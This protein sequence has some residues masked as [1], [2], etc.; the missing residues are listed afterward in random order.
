M[1]A[2]I[3]RT[4]RKAVA[5]IPVTQTRP[6]PKR[7]S[8]RTTAPP[9]FAATPGELALV[10][11]AAAIVNPW[12]AGH[13]GIPYGSP[14]PTYKQIVYDTFLV[15]SGTQSGN[16]WDSNSG[17]LAIGE[18]GIYVNVKLQYSGLTIKHGSGTD[19]LPV[20]QI[21]R[22]VSITGG[23]MVAAA[24]RYE[25]GGRDDAFGGFAEVGRTCFDGEEVLP[26]DLRRNGVVNYYPRTPFDVEFKDSNGNLMF[27][28][29]LALLLKTVEPGA[30]YRFQVIAIVE[31]ND[32][33]PAPVD[34]TVGAYTTMNYGPTP[35]AGERLMNSLP[36]ITAAARDAP[37]SKSKPAD[38]DPSKWRGGDWLK[39]LD[40]AAGMLSQGAIVGNSVINALSQ[41]KNMARLVGPAMALLTP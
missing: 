30:P 5:G 24:I 41:A 37:Y 32:D 19:G 22:S 40:R 18:N 31:S 13:V 23:R 39:S 26:L 29:T 15:T 1:R 2:E 35:L 36:L 27:D 8:R 20:L 16:A 38:A 28:S 25:Y 17:V 12:D 34:Y 11:Y 21:E 9:P 4:V 6:P 14:L 10:E 33:T 3:N 7:P